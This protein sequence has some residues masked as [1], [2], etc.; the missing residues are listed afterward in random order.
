MRLLASRGESLVRNSCVNQFQFG[1]ISGS[2]PVRR[3]VGLLYSEGP[4]KLR[5]K[6]GY[7]FRMHEQSALSKHQ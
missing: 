5:I 6:L 3:G 7:S 2:T 1:S 4:K